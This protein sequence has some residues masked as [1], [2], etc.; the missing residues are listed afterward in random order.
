MK[1]CLSVE[2]WFFDLSQRFV[3]NDEVRPGE[4][5]ITYSMRVSLWQHMAYQQHQ[6]GGAVHGEDRWPAPS[7]DH[8]FSS[9]GRTHP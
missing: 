4:W 5:A 7:K 2:L 6:F 8:G 1:G 3:T 9:D